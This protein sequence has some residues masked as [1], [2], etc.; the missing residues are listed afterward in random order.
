MLTE[1]SLFLSTANLPDSSIAPYATTLSTGVHYGFA[2]V[3]PLSSSEAGSSSSDDAA[4][5]DVVWP[6]VMSIGWNP[7]YNNTTRTA[8][9]PLFVLGPSRE[10]NAGAD[11][12]LVLR[13][14]TSS[15]T[16]HTTSTAASYAS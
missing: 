14:S 2:R 8:V 3:V 13:R 4:V 7:F 11:C 1:L 12:V 16:T 15:T 5:H 10:W 9:R 6:M